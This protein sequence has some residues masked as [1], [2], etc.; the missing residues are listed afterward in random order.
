VKKENVSFFLPPILTNISYPDRKMHAPLVAAPPTALL[1]L[2]ATGSPGY[3]SGNF[4]SAR[5]ADLKKGF[6][7]LHLVV[8]VVLLLL[9]LLWTG[10]NSGSP[11]C[12][13]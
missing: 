1:H 13:G 9:L 11:G 2:T 10:A 4:L 6:Q 12:S 5:K 3:L 8:V 7:H